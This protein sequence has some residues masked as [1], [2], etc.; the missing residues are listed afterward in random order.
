MASSSFLPFRRRWALVVLASAGALFACNQILGVEDVKL[1][2]NGTRLNNDG[3]EVTGDDDDIV[4]PPGTLQ[5]GEAPPAEDPA[6][7]TLALGFSHSCA[8]MLDSTVRCWGTN[9]SGQLGD[10][11]DAGS[12]DA[13]D[14]L[15]PTNV[16][17]LT[18]AVAIAAGTTHTCAVRKS[19]KVSC[20]GSGFSGALGNGKDDSSSLPVDVTGVDDAIAIGA[21]GAVTCI[22]HK[23]GTASCWGSNSNGG[24]GDGTT[25]DSKVP[26]AVNDLKDIVQIAPS[27]NHTC[28]VLKSGDVYCWGGASDGQLGTGS[29]T[30]TTK[31][32]KLTALSDVAQIAVASRYGC[33]R[34]KSGSVACWGRNE[35]GQLGNGSPTDSP[36][37][38]PIAVPFVSDAVSI[39]C[40]YG[41]TCAVRKT[42]AVACWGD[43]TYGQL[44]IG[45]VDAGGGTISKST[46]QAVLNLTTAKSVWTGGDRTCA[47]TSD[48]K[49]LCWG[50]NF[51]GELGNGSTDQKDVPTPVSDFN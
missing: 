30:P 1:K 33:A 13:P 11:S 51:D 45:P 23:T 4:T 12:G 40:G 41:H 5:D 24:L 20:W 50:S 37:P 25:A 3:G 31:P 22:I 49:A 36:N 21:G 27:T 29:L 38:S 15:R 48:N 46:P 17:G 9:Y 6:R 42:G 43:A 35:S 10:G 19:G 16:K 2:V 39:W 32:T 47:V 18:D 34:M 28:A 8:R 44:G 14:Q 7:P 26:V